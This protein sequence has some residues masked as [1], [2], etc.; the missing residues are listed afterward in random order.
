VLQVGE[1]L[2]TS[3]RQLRLGLKN[4]KGKV[5]IHPDIRR[6]CKK[7]QASAPSRKSGSHAP[8]EPRS[9]TSAMTSFF[10]ILSYSIPHQLTKNPQSPSG[11]W[12]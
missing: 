5:L 12:G 1:E 10:P 9:P 4:I 3:G 7:P 6:T 2:A 11:G 8:S